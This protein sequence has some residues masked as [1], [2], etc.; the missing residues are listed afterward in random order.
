MVAGRTRRIAHPALLAAAAAVVGALVLVTGGILGQSRELRAAATGD[1]EAYV[2]AN[3]AAN[4]LSDL[5]VTEISAVAARGSGSALYTDFREGAEDL[6]D[7]IGAAPGNEEAVLALGDAVDDYVASVDGDGGVRSTD[8]EAGD[9]R[10]AADITLSGAS[11]DAFQTADDIAT[12]NVADEDESLAARL[13]AARDADV[14]PALPIVL[15]V[16]AAVLA[17]AGTLARGRRYR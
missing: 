10:G 8:L 2:A 7:Q 6:R 3:E 9:N 14:E 15:G 11:F 16:L 1:I 13:D 5:R 12:D 17:A 4:D